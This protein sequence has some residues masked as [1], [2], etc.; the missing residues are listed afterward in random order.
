M[1]KYKIKILVLIFLLNS[2]KL[3]KNEFDFLE[4]N[5]LKNYVIRK[6]IDI[7]ES[8]IILIGNYYN[9]VEELNKIINDLKEKKIIDNDYNLIK[10]NH[11]IVIYIDQ[12]MFNQECLDIIQKIKKNR[13]SGNN[14]YNVFILN[15]SCIDNNINLPLALF[16]RK[17][18]KTKKKISYYFEKNDGSDYFKNNH[19]L[20]D[21]NIKKVDH[22]KKEI[23]FYN[24]KSKSF[25]DYYDENRKKITHDKNDYKKTPERDNK[26]LIHYLTKSLNN[27]DLNK[28]L[29]SSSVS[30]SSTSSS[31]VSS[32]SSSSSSSTSS[33][34]SPIIDYIINE[35]FLDEKNYENNNNLYLRYDI[36][37]Y[38]SALNKSQKEGKG[39]GKIKEKED[40]KKQLGGDMYSLI[41][42]GYLKEDENGIWILEDNND[43]II[44]FNESTGQEINEIIEKNYNNQLLI[45]ENLTT[46]IKNILQS[47]S[48]SS[49]SSI[50][51]KDK[52]DGKELNSTNS[53]SSSLQPINEEGKEKDKEKIKEFLK[54]LEK[55]DKQINHS[56]LEDEH[57]KKEDKW[58][59][60]SHSGFNINDKKLELF[61]SNEEEEMLY[62][63]DF[64][65]N[66]KINDKLYQSKNNSQNKDYIYIKDKINN[67]IYGQKINDELIGYKIIINGDKQ[68]KYEGRINLNTKNLVG[69]GKLSVYNNY[70]FNYSYKYKFKRLSNFNDHIA[71]IQDIIIDEEEE[72]KGID[73]VEETKQNAY[74]ISDLLQLIKTNEENK[75]S[76][77]EQKKSYENMRII[78]EDLLILRSKNNEEIN[79]LS[80][81]EKREYYEIIENNIK[82]FLIEN[83]KFSFTGFYNGN[84]YKNGI[85]IDMSEIQT[86]SRR[87]YTREGDRNESGRGR[88]DESGRERGR[89]DTGKVNSKPSTITS[90]RNERER[91]RGRGRGRGNNYYQQQNQSKF[92]KPYQQQLQFND[93]YHQQQLQFNDQYQMLHQNLYNQ[94][95][96]ASQFYYPYY[97]NQYNQQQ[98]QQQFSPPSSQQNQYNQQQQFQ[99]KKNF[100]SS[101]PPSRQQNQNNKNNSRSISQQQNQRS[102][103]EEKEYTT[104]DLIQ[105]IKQNELIKKNTNLSSR[106]KEYDEYI[107]EDFKKLES[108]TD[109]E[110]QKLSPNEKKDYYD[111]IN[112]YKK[113]GS[114]SSTTTPRSSKF[115]L[116]K[117][118]LEISN[119]KDFLNCNFNFNEENLD[120]FNIEENLDKFNI[121]RIISGLK[122]YNNIDDDSIYIMSFLKNKE[123]DDKTVYGILDLDTGEI[124]KINIL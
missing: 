53:L 67:I 14:F 17:R 76:L 2:N 88:G 8:K 7:D 3:K 50:S 32:S 56:K 34:L 24:N 70:N 77:L 5:K 26:P 33:L 83:E 44:E 12:N 103:Q 62:V 54:I 98:F 108:K 27:V 42:I 35:I 38:I 20:D 107:N 61:L 1:K 13:N 65:Y 60:F 91:G 10:N 100:R 118:E 90:S 45:G 99:Q 84:F 40:G 52:E 37:D 116:N 29:Q 58:Y 47:S 15:G 31:S 81:N 120:K 89:E 94:Q 25:W 30:S 59:Q 72:A 114:Q 86:S 68:L 64:D 80:D 55:L 104:S 110:I 92:N 87:E 23:I 121:K 51:F 105:L 117:N 4:E 115:D 9:K 73:E 119:P 102:Q 19:I 93:Q 106:N 124:K 57:K 39:K 16:F 122:N 11:F 63:P 82:K 66:N 111:I 18:S 28:L 22:L 46:Y 101:S 95:E 6:S 97:Q 21:Y 75:N 96:I 43:N 69:Y 48:S 112:R 85:Q 41:D 74:T 109:E 78:Y 71:K 123:E 36:S 79:K 49:S 113:G